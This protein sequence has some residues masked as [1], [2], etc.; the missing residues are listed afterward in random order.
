VRYEPAGA[1]PVQTSCQPGTLA[2]A[3]AVRAAYPELESMSRIYGCFNRKRIAGT[4]RWSLHAEGRAFDVGVQ[5]DELEVGWHLACV[6]VAERVFFGVQ[7]VIWDKHI[8]SIENASAWRRLRPQSQQHRDHVHV[9][10]YRNAA[11][12]PVSMRATYE[13]KLKL[14][15]NR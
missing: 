5:A 14:H 4:A 7:R 9:E 11:A 13:A 3:Q 8:W 10:Q 2:L 12:R 6:L 1:A 15:R